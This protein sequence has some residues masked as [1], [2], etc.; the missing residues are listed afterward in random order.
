M[1]RSERRSYD[2]RVHAVIREV[3]PEPQ[4]TLLAQEMLAT[5]D[6]MLTSPLSDTAHRISR[7]SVVVVADGQ[8][9]PIKLVLARGADHDAVHLTLPRPLRPLSTPCSSCEGVG[10]AEL[11]TLALCTECHGLG[12]V[13]VEEKVGSL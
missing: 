4:L 6:D 2:L 11:A 7:M 8:P 5:I 10:W 9:V 1:S 12:H 3:V 13:E